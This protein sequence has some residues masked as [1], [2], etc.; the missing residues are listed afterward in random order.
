MIIKY[1]ILLYSDITNNNVYIL[2]GCRFILR[3]ASQPTSKAY[4]KL[5]LEKA[6]R[7]LV[8]IICINNNG[9]RVIQFKKIETF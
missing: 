2:V 4:I 3:Q 1:Q 7:I 9:A 6:E 5:R 8:R